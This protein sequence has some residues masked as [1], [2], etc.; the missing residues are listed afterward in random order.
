MLLA[1]AASIAFVG[2][3]IRAF[4]L[5]WIA[6]TQ[7]VMAVNRWHDLAGYAIVALVFLGTMLLASSFTRSKKQRATSKLESKKYAVEKEAE[8]EGHRLG[9]L[10]STFSFL[11]C[12]LTWIVAV[13]VSAHAWYRAHEHD[14]ARATRWEVQ[15][16]QSASNFHEIKI[17]DAERRIL[18]FDRV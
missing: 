9:F 3:C 8:I 6:A 14:L 16:P 15:W 1:A 5:V 13:E 7:N 12:A 17:E 4:V 18:S 11:L 10:L 2:N